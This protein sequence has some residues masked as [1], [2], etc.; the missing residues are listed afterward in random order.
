MRAEIEITP[1]YK[2]RDVGFDRSMV[3]GYGHDDRVDAYP[4]LM[5]EIETK[6][7]PTP[8]FVSSPIRKRSGQ[9]V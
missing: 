5:A 2:C 1:A 3:G 9:T 4:A 7:R 8:P 6:P